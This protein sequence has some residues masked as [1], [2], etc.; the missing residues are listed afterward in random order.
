ME[1]VEAKDEQTLEVTGGDEP[2][3]IKV[4]RPSWGDLI[5]QAGK[6]AQLFGGLAGD[7]LQ[8]A[9]SVAAGAGGQAAAAA[10]DAAKQAAAAFGAA[11]D[12][13]T[14]GNLKDAGGRYAIPEPLLS[15]SEE[16]EL[17]KLT[18]QY[19]KLR[20]PGAISK[21]GN[22][23]GEALPKELK[24]MAENAGAS[25]TEQQ[26]YLQVMQVVADGFEVIEGIAARCSVG[27]D[28][29]V[30]QINRGKQSQKVDD[31][32]EICLL[33]ATDVAK[34]VN[35]QQLQHIALAFTEGAATGAP[36]FAGI[37]FNIAAS[38]FL[39]FRAV[40]SIA[41]FYGYDVKNDPAEMMIASEVFGAAMNPSAAP[42]GG[43]STSV[44]KIMAAAEVTMV[45]Q[46][47]KK[48]W[49]EMAK[50]GGATLILA[51]IR[52]L[53]NA[54]ARKAVQNAGKKTLEKT[55]YATV[56]EQVGK[57]LT[58]KAIS[59]SVPVVGGVIGAAFDTS[60]MN[61]ILTYASIFYEKRFILEKEQRVEALVAG[62]SVDELL[63]EEGIEI[64]AVV[65][66]AQ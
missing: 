6:T 19:D 39:F 22:M 63:H 58:Q 20:E 4:P 13:E 42:T 48:G 17:Q 61:K 47:V 11:S 40:Q 7:A 15:P 16:Q 57:G 32:S 27:P 43:L 54:A 44:A 31:I 56:L 14:P 65:E 24:E 28:Y 1:N 41:L 3:Q 60:Q 21:I 10:A 8:K 49:T 26:L 59:R 45:G 9:G 62:V 52:A 12:Q 30:N 36:G 64:D 35:D 18:A 46:V 38:T 33:R 66:D 29:V 53:A 5:N 50:R 37:P 55:A 25:F 2:T 23:V 51:Q 34:I